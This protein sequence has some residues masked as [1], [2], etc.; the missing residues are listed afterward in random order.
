MGTSSDAAGQGSGASVDSE[1]DQVERR[2]G[3]LLLH[4]FHMLELA[5]PIAGTKP[6]P[7]RHG[8]S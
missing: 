2:D 5:V 4:C 3:A 7:G 6:D 8:I 1:Q